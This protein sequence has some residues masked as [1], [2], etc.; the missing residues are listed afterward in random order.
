VGFS[1]DDNK[2]NWMKAIADDDLT[3]D[4]FSELKQWDA[5]T[6][7]LYNISSI[8]ASFIINPEGIIIAKNLRGEALNE[9]LKKNL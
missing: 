7:Q 9:F 8:P 1:L 3:W 6:A 2:D 4:H 5:P